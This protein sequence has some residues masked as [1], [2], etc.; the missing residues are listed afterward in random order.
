MRLGRRPLALVAAIALTACGSPAA[1]HSSRADPLEVT[2]SSDDTGATTG[3][4]DTSASTDST[5]PSK[6]TLDWV[7]CDDPVVEDPTLECTTLQVPLD[8]DEPTGETID[9]ALIRVP[10]VEDRQGAVLFNPGGPGASAFDY[11]AAGGTTYTAAL[12]TQAFDFVGFDPRGVDRSSGIRCVSDEFLDDHLYVDDTPDTPEEKALSDESRDGFVDACTEKYGDTL[13]FYS[14]ENTARDMDAIRIALGDEQ[15]SFLGVSYGTYLGATYATMFPDRV[16]AMV[17]DS[18]VETNGDTTQQAL[19]TQLIGFEGAFDNWAAWCKGDATCDFTAADVGARWDALKQ[20]LDQVPI[21]ASDGRIANNATMESAT[22]AALYSESEWRPLAQALAEAEDGDPEGIFAIA[23]AY[24]RRDEDGTFASLFQSFPVIRCASGMEPPPADDPAALA[25]TL[26]SLAPR[27]GKSITAEDVTFEHE[28]C[29]RLAADAEPIPFS[30]SGDGPIALIGGLNDPATPIRWARKMLGELGPNARLVTSTG[31]GHGQLLVNACVT[32]I[33]GALLV[34]L[35]LPE[36][37]TVCEPDPIVAK[38][39]WWDDLPVPDGMSPVVSFPQLAAK[40]GADP[41]LV[42]SEMRTTSVSASAAVA[43]YTE[44]LTE[45]GFEEFESP[46]TMPLD[47]VAQGT[48]TDGGDRTMVVIA[49]GPKAFD[50][51]QLIDAKAEV[52]PDTT[53]VWLIAVDI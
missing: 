29:D 22:L 49:L 26:R 35:T 9:L 47:D 18:V 20:Q 48:Y 6:G 40:L 16:R 19:E 25:A 33:E 14:T 45:A 39:D 31:E 21:A 42:F 53:V 46:S 28:K 3:P 36:P 15:L 11:V 7:A 34:D 10:A 17:L 27:F 8:Y 12:G 30:Y 41:S 2:V 50:D 51:E 44:T 4:S 13:R 43:A 23:D 1:V 32:E 38:P 52:P 37:D 5:T 24:N